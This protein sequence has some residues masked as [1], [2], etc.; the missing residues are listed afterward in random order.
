MEA[1]LRSML[2]SVRHMV[3][4]SRVT[5]TLAR[6]EEVDG[7]SRLEVHPTTVPVAELLDAIL[8]GDQDRLG[9]EIPGP[10]GVTYRLTLTME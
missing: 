5:L 6:Q 10:D 8:G 2:P 7:V 9:L 3:G 1:L 4:D